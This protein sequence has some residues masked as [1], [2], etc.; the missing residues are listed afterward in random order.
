MAPITRHSF[1]RMQLS[2]WIVLVVIKNG[3]GKHPQ[4]TFELETDSCRIFIIEGVITVVTTIIGLPTIPAWTE[5]S[6]FLKPEEK[7]YLLR[8]LEDDA[9]PCRPG[10]YNVTFMKNGIIDD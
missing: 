8:M 4:N 5:K 6:T 1:L 9:G 3:D 10:H 7:A 2:I